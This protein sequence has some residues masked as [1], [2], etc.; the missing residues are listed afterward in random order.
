[1][2]FAINVF[3]MS[4]FTYPIVAHWAWSPEGWLYKKG[5]QDIAGS[6]KQDSFNSMGRHAQLET[7]FQ[8]FVV[9]AV[10]HIVGGATG[11]VG[12]KL[13]GPRFRKML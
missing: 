4:T 13:L 9:L 12:T 2:G 6:G 5:F 3:F 8:N 7:C 10:V 1:M 11:L